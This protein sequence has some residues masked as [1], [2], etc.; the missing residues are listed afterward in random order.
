M[1]DKSTTG[2]TWS[3]EIQHIFTETDKLDEYDH[4]NNTSTTHHL[5]DI[6][7]TVKDRLMDTYITSWKD[8]LANQPKLRS[9]VKFKDT[10]ITES[11][12]QTY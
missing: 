3:K 10:Y 1:W 8:D 7:K 5:Q 12:A 2:H 4:I 11:Y 9:Y 6:L